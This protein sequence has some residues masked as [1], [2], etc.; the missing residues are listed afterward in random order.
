M[1]PQKSAQQLR[2]AII[3]LQEQNYNWNTALKLSE[4]INKTR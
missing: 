2:M 3:S 1:E 4:Q